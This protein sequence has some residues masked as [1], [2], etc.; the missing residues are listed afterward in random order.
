MRI[1]KYENRVFRAFFDDK[2]LQRFSDLSLADSSV[3]VISAI[4]F[5]TESSIFAIFFATFESTGSGAWTIL[6]MGVLYQA[7]G[8]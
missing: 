8:Q 1:D 3:V 2:E 7:N 5:L 4:S 6:Y